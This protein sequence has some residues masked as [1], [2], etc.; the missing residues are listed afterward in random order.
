MPSFEKLTTKAKQA[1]QR[2]HE[3]AME[4][5][6][7]HVNVAHLLTALILQDESPV[8][9]VLER[10]E[11]D[12]IALS[13]Q[14]LDVIETGE[15]ANAGN[16]SQMIQMFIAPDLAQVLERSV[17]IA[18]SMKDEFVSVEHLFLASLALPHS[19]HQYLEKQ[20][21]TYDRV[22]K[23]LQDI[24][25]HGDKGGDPKKQFRA[26]SKYSRNLT[27]LAKEDKLDPVIGRD[28]EIMRVIEILARRTK[29]N[30]I[31]IGEPGTG[32]TAIAEGLAIRI[33]KGDVPESLRG[34][35]LVLLDMGLLIAGTKYRGEFEE[36][37]KS[38]MKEIE[39][40][41]GQVIVFIDEIHTI[42]GAGGSDGSM[43]MSN[44]LKPA[45]A[46]GEFR[47]IGATT[48]NEF[49]KHFE[50][51]PALARRF[52]P[53]YV[54]E[55]SEEDAI[56]I[57]RGLKYKYELY[58]GVRITDAAIVSAVNLSVRY[59][60]NRFLPDKAVDLIDEAASM[61]KI[62]L[63]NKPAL[64]DEAHRKI[65]RLEIEREAL[66]RE[67]ENNK[68]KT[69]TKHRIKEI[70]QE[71][72]NVRETTN[73]LETRWN[74]E[75]E[76]IA[77]TRK[78]KKE[79]DLM[80]VEAE[81]AEQQTDLARVAEIRY[82]KI[83]ALEKNLKTRMDR[84]KKI[85]DDDRL[86]REE[87]TEDD[88]ARV[89]AKWTHIPVTKMLQAET[90]RLMHMEDELKNRVKGQDEAIEK[91]SNAIR[92]SRVGISDPNRPIGS[93]MFLGPTGVGKTE[94][95]KALAEYMFDD[96]KALIRVD[97][98]EYMEKHS[99]SKLVGTAPGYVGY[100]E[101]GQFTEAVRHRP[102]SVILFDEV[103]KAHPDVFNIL[104]QVL[105][106]GH[107]KDGK[108]RVVNF[109]NTI[110][111]MTSNIGSQH[112]Q[113]MQTMGFSGND[114]V[115]DYTATK[116]RVLESLKDFFRPEFLNRLDDT[117]VFDVLSKEIISN[118]VHIR[119][120]QVLKRMQEK[121]I[122]LDLK[123]AVIEYLAEKGYDPQFGARPLN[124]VIQT[125]LLNKLATM[126]ISGEITGGNTVIVDM[127]KDEM[128]FEI[129]KKGLKISR[130]NLAK[131]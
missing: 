117:I 22:L 58:H 81:N 6:Q 11:V 24:K 15:Q 63:E 96:E 126:I 64:L 91:I 21:I 124:R 110:I 88:I 31:L 26:L 100:D 113:K 84:L 5:G 40:S 123:P 8:V 23:V 60:T 13:D 98:S 4:R 125:T 92:R 45:L 7:D 80:R 104:L 36:R 44:M 68:E 30:P 131:A 73:S 62:S 28:K 33:A 18:E 56:A 114:S 94:L 41:E 55:P 32:K 86:M 82:G 121:D 27:K 89:V 20:D 122:T 103:E 19:V 42:I 116:E 67:V 12:M 43:D 102:Y 47:A 39:Q 127:K 87:V 101:A 85:K 2:S 128:V 35:D 29:N 111:I 9:S 10:L 118:I 95:T 66:T 25:E 61:L 49:Q 129:K 65:T 59:I 14:L 70:A 78:I 72:A 3:L 120:A 37:L 130:Q 51:D 93:F 90:K 53:V 54:N 1:L 109:K 105:D 106:D 50:K 108:G 115:Q 52:Q 99:V 34:K 77:E 74:T 16:Q 38:I 79:I 71:I 83:P 57:M 107:L 48:I 112:I 17:Q 76:I 46:R 69:D 119:V 97:M 75:K